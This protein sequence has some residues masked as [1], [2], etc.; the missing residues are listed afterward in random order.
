M[1]RPNL[2]PVP[3]GT[4]VLALTTDGQPVGMYAFTTPSAIGL[5]KKCPTGMRT[6]EELHAWLTAAE[7]LVCESVPSDQWQRVASE[8]DRLL[9][10]QKLD[11]S[12]EHTSELQSPCNL[13]CRLLLE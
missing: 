9:A 1:A 2:G 8:E 12:E 6:L 11:R 7:G 13:V 10:E 3:F 4:K 5:L